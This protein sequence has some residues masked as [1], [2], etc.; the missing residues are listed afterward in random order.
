M[1]TTVSANPNTHVMADGRKVSRLAQR[2]AQ[3]GK[4][5]FVYELDAGQEF[6]DGNGRKKVMTQGLPLGGDCAASRFS[7]FETQTG[8]QSPFSLAAGDPVGDEL[9]R[10]AR[11]YPL[12]ADKLKADHKPPTPEIEP[13][14]FDFGR[15]SIAVQVQATLR[16]T[17]EE[18]LDNLRKHSRGNLGLHGV[19]EGPA[20]EDEKFLPIGI[21][22]S[23]QAAVAIATGS[24]IIRSRYPL[25]T[26]ADV[27]ASEELSRRVGFTAQYHRKPDSF[28]DVYTLLDGYHTRT[29]VSGSGTS[30]TLS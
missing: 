18:I 26:V 2:C 9:S 14:L 5:Y 17:R 10:L 28:M 16:L 3:T 21:S 8:H 23:R 13:G 19:V 12:L 22:V 30:A 20:T 1:S 4:A 29:L 7:R 15:V 6:I 25:W 24:G 27:E 11:E